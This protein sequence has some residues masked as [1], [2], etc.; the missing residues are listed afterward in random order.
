MLQAKLE[1][2]QRDTFGKQ[3]ARDLR[4]K[5]GVPAVLYGRAQDTVSIQLNARAFNQFLR[6][7]GENVVINM[8]IGDAES[9]TVVIKEIQR[10][11]VEKHTLVHADFIRISLDEPVTSAVPVV[12]E[13]NPPG[14]QEGGVLEFPLRHVSLHC[15]PMRTPT[16]ISVDVGELDIGDSIYVSDLSL[17]EDIEI[18]DEPQRIIATVSQPR[19]QLEEETPELEEGEEGEGE[20]EEGEEAAEQP[21]EPEVISRRRRDDDED[22]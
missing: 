12:L 7:Y 6:T 15:L 21:S 20:G 9:E 13:G 8:V 3:S 2:Q 1:V 11:P 16:D 14:V 19:V 10:H 22:E 18:L 17:D 5:G 4:R